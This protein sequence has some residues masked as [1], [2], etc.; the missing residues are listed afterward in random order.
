MNLTYGSLATDGETLVYEL[1]TRPDRNAVILHGAGQANRKRYYA[2]AE[3][4]EK[5][6]IGVL[7]FDFSGHGESSGQISEL[8]LKRRAKQAQAMIDQLL[9]KM[10]ELYLM[11]FSMSGQTVCD[12]L[13]IYATRVKAILLGCPAM[14]TRSVHAMAFGNEL[15]SAMIRQ[16]ESWRQSDAPAKLAAFH[17]KTILAVGSNDEV[18]PSGVVQLYRESARQCMFHEFPEVSHALAPW[19]AGHPKE[20]AE[21]LREL[22][23]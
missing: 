19:L 18:I 7:L 21:L 23:S 20:L 17:G 13:P 22:I 12:L 6:G 14:Y 2:V 16:H 11:G 10:S 9:P 5:Q 4:L 8:S 1:H 15:F 3:A